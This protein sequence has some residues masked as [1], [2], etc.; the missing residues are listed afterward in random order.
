MPQRLQNL[1]S[2]FFARLVQATVA[3]QAAGHDMIVLGQGN[4][5]QPTPPHI[6]AAGQ[7]ALADPRT[8][9]YPPFSGLFAFKEAAARWYKE[10]YDVTL[11]PEQEICVVQGSK[12]A[13]QEIALCYLEPGDICLVPDPGYP[14][15][16]SGIALAG[17]RA[18]GVPLTQE[19]GF[20]PD[21]A[22]LSTQDL[23]ATRL[24]L[25]NFP[26]NPTGQVATPSVYA[27]AIRLAQQYGFI[28]GSDLAYGDLVFDNKRPISFLQQPGARDLGV[29]FVTLSKSYNMAGWRIGFV[30]GNREVIARLNLIQDHLHC[31]QSAAIQQ[32][33][34]TALSGPQ[35]SVR[36]LRDL[37]QERRDAWV[38]GCRAIGWP[39][40]PSAG[41]FYVWCKVPGGF[42]SERF[43]DLLLQQAHVVVAPGNGFGSHG[44]G[45]V[46]VS[47]TAPTPRIKE[48]T[49]RIGRLVKAGTIQF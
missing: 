31:S 45:Y 35:D 44:E 23:A 15:Y 21:F 24:L 3:M 10:T 42:T 43:A 12:I 7:A 37:Y 25:L 5:D 39:V 9:R 13:L 40:T 34:I 19:S 46:R 1:P 6:V 22:S 32:A 30:A 41:T 20:L 48:A 27:E 17:A 49:E 2:Q 38:A 8:H 33:A 4:P 18:V 28:V 14:D 36:E 29:E 47:L 11:D 26:S 16:L